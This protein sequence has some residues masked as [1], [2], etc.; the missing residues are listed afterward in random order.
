MSILIS[1]E[2][3]VPPL[4]LEERIN[5]INNHPVFCLLQPESISH[6]AS[7]FN[8]IHIKKNE[9]VV[10]EE[11]NFD[12]FMLIVSGTAVVSRSLKRIK[13]TNAIQITTLG[14]N[15][16]I[17]L[18]NTGYFSKQGKRTATVTALSS[19]VVL[20][21]DILTFCYF[22]KEHAPI[23]SSLISSSEKFL[24]HH[25]LQDNACLFHPTINGGNLGKKLTIIDKEQMILKL[26]NDNNIL[27]DILNVNSP[28]SWDECKPLIREKLKQLGFCE[29]DLITKKV[30]SSPSR[31]ITKLIRRVACWGKGNIPSDKNK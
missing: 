24:L 10:Q 26:N 12:G 5:H 1:E 6:L 25:Y 21:I 18:G 29:F 13:K 19:M 8:E 3:F 31:F 28:A 23:Y 11:D 16:A 9:V 15:R 17:G 22:L 7:L 27:R 4:S 14:P 30:G 20:H 2:H